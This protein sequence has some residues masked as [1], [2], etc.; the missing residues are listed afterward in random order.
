VE[1]AAHG[2][3]DYLRQ[4]DNDWDVLGAVPAAIA[5]V[6]NRYRWQILLKFMPEMLTHVPDLAELKMLV[7]S[8]ADTAT[9]QVR[10]SIDVDPLTIL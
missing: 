8:L 9:K 10:V 7:S 1:L 3:A 6:S 4:L 2:L 5:K